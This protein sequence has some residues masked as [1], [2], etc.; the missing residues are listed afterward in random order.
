MVFHYASQWFGEGAVSQPVDAVAKKL[1]ADLRDLRKEAD[2]ENR[3]IIF[4]GHSLGGI[5]IE[6]AVITAKLQ[7]VPYL[8]VFNAMAGCVFLGCPFTGS[9]SQMKAALASTLLSTINMSKNT[10][11][12]KMLSEQNQ[13]LI[14]MRND[15]LNIVEQTRMQT[16]NFWE[17][18][19]TNMNKFS[20]SSPWLSWSAVSQ[21]I[22]P[23]ETVEFPGKAG[24]ALNTDHSGLNK[25]DSP[26]NGHWITVKNQ[27][28]E[29]A[30]EAGK[31]VKAR[32][33]SLSPKVDEATFEKMRKA[34]LVNMDDPEIDFNDIVDTRKDSMEATSKMTLGIPKLTRFIEGPTPGALML[35]LHAGMD[36]GMRAVAIINKIDEMS[37]ELGSADRAP[38]KCCYFFADNTQRKNNALS[39]VKAFC[40]QLIASSKRL[41]EHLPGDH[42]SSHKRLTYDSLSTLADPFVSMTRDQ[43]VGTVYVIIDAIDQIDEHSRKEFFETVMKESLFT[44]ADDPTKWTVK[45]KYI[46]IGLARNDIMEAMEKIQNGI[47]LSPEQL[48]TEAQ[49]LDSLKV[50]VRHKVT[51]LAKRMKYRKALLF[52]LRTEILQRSEGNATWYVEFLY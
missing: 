11:M 38:L 30:N 16:C 28:K 40:L 27:I 24:F 5:V 4:I 3:P 49:L 42:K 9:P 47:I 23:K 25:F 18:Q 14:D 48:G 45:V 36:K 15:F 22:A 37:K 41:A 20:N 31:A 1:I 51:E 26:N 43:A 2:C 44:S 12:I 39:M 50:M 10:P 35:T 7:G 17:L 46:F 8:R 32:L 52:S 29:I 33:N 34:L 19:E 6:K 21:L 13:Q